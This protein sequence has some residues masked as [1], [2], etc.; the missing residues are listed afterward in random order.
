MLQC[1]EAF[2]KRKKGLADA[3]WPEA[4]AQR[5]EDLSLTPDSTR[6]FMPEQRFLSRFRTMNRQVQRGFSDIG[7][8][9]LGT[10][11]YFIKIVTLTSLKFT[12]SYA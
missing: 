5:L 2:S 1:E 3:Q 11:T 9:D 12:E 4:L 10:H 6:Y 7:S 8:L